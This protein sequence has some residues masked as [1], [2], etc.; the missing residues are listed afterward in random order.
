MINILLRILI[1][2]KKNNI[3]SSIFYNFLWLVII[4][5][6]FILKMAIYYNCVRFH[7]RNQSFL[8][9]NKN[10]IKIVFFINYLHY[11]LHCTIFHFFQI[12]LYFFHLNKLFLFILYIK[13][14]IFT[15]RTFINVKLIIL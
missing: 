11:Q 3:T 13:K 5:I 6:A 14:K 10:K 8:K 7:C 15:I 1:N 4:V 12:I 2:N 9:Q